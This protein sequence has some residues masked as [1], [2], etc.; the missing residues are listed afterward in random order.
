MA[1]A[2]LATLPRSGD[3]TRFAYTAFISYSHAAD[4]HLAAFLQTALQGF[5][6]PWYRRRA[7]R[8]FRD[9][10]GLELTPDLWGAIRSALESSEYFVLLA[11]ERAAQSPWIELE[12]D[13]WLRIAGADRVLIVWTDGELAWDSAA[14]DFDWTRSTCLH[15]RLR[16]VFR[17]EPLHLD[18]RS[19]RKA[20]DLSLQRPQFVNAIARLS[21]TLRHLPL[22]DLIGE[23]VA[24]HRRTRRIAGTAITTLS[25]LLAAA[26]A[27]AWFA[28]QQRNAARR[29]LVDL[30]VTNG[31]NEV[32]EGDLSAGALWFA[33]A[34]RLAE[35]QPAE[36]QLQ[37][38]RLRTTVQAHPAVQQAWFTD[39]TLNHRG[40]VFDRDGRY[41][42]SH[43]REGATGTDTGVGATRSGAPGPRAWDALTGA[44]LLF[45]L[46]SD[47]ADVLAVDAA[48][49]HIRVLTTG[50]GDIV[51]LLDGRSG[52]EIAR[53]E[54]AG[55][56]V[57]AA[58]GRDGAVVLT[59]SRDG[60]VR[61]WNA[62]DGRLL[63]SF[64]HESAPWYAGLTADD[65]TLFS[66]TSD[67]V[68][69]I[70]QLGIDDHGGAQFS[71]EHEDAV[72]QIDVS[73]DGRH[74]VTVESRTARLWDL[75]SE[76]KPSLLRS[77]AGVNHAEFNPGGTTLLLADDFGE[78]SVFTLDPVELLVVVRHD[79]FVLHATFSPDGTQF[80][81]AG[82]DRTARVWDA[83]SGTPL[84]PLLYH[85]QT[86]THAAFDPQ[87]GHLVTTTT[88]GVIRVWSL[89]RRPTALR[90]ESVRHVERHPDGR[91]FLTVSYGDIKVWDL[92]GSALLTL[93]VPSQIH[94]AGFSPDGRYIVSASQDGVANVWDAAT[95]AEVHALRHGR[96]LS[97][98]SVRPDGA[99]LATTSA[100]TAN[101]NVW[102]LATG[103]MLFSLPHESETP[104]RTE[105]SPDGTKLLMFGRGTAS[106]WDLVN[107]R[108]LDAFRFDEDITTASFSPDGNLIVVLAGRSVVKVY[109][110]S[111]AAPVGTAIRH[112]NY[113][114]DYVAFAD[115]T[116]LLVAGG[117]Y[118]RVWDA[119]TATPRT[120]P[121]THGPRTNVAWGVASHDGE[122][123]AT[124]ADPDRTVRVWHART[125]RALT[126]PLR[127]GAGLREV[128]FDRGGSRIV[129][130]G[131]NS[132][133]IWPV[134]GGG[135]ADDAGLARYAR[136]IAARQI[137]TT[138][139]IVPFETTPLREAWEAYQADA[140][141]RR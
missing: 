113:F 49:G 9:T 16:G 130:A 28:F 123:L 52:A 53:F 90:H 79:G 38:L 23:D 3:P 122:L 22:D 136:I 141:A 98:V 1:N 41:V 24:Q 92:E 78:A 134:S 135:S 29:A 99:W 58:F 57:A 85:E 5:A 126:P 51:R 33:E 42:I 127:H 94:H 65:R 48:A 74:V 35:D 12:L 133:R 89:D 20:E 62:A 91:R 106:M 17:A 125:A 4:G 121:L 82:T 100:A 69:R 70:W 117:G 25:V 2:D 30:M 7:I 66:A 118:L 109:D 34:L 39:P 31:L 59:E 6:K 111:G 45:Q 115:S 15:P 81:T 103:K 61:M 138:G 27:A 116:T 84:S 114:I 112:E 86:V 124:A 140:N 10:T 131:G 120:P 108:R 128:V 75:S 46:P 77:W 107:R 63:R 101:V 83:S 56:V 32:E 64:E 119:R 36:Q 13:T 73:S 104:D 96:R 19:A 137:D 11:S 43:P 18:L 105:F 8:V 71:L 14:G 72:E 68:A 129:T 87:K 26:V 50:A 88:E 67:G 60:I 97:H 110:V 95:G 80:A 44:P 93:P 54:D 47:A 40:A 21:A 76:E 55:D 139:G 102:D 132:V 37:R